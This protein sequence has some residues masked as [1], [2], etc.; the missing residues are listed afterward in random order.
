[1][2][3]NMKVHIFDVEHGS[4]NVIQTP[5]G[6]LIMIDCGHNTSTGWRPSNW[7]L[8]NGLSISNLAISNID[9]DHVSDLVNIDRCCMPDTI[10]TNWHLSADWIERK[11]KEIGGIG[12]G[13][14]KLL[15][16][17]QKIYTGDGIAV[18]YGLARK[19]FCL[20]TKDFTDFNNL[21]M[22]TFFQYAGFCIIFPGDLLKEGWKELL[23][24]S[25]FTNW[26]GKVNIFVASHHGRE[27]GYYEEVFHYCTPDIFIIS[28][29]PIKHDTQMHDKYSSQS[30]GILFGQK[31]RR[32]LTTRKDNKITIHVEPTG[33]YTIYTQS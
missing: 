3:D 10:K 22:V 26:L 31:R 5:N 4:C 1:M 21:S 13:V 11:K 7:I 8:S 2:A 30:T 32:V 12:P 6:K 16:Y 18:D 19:R 27:N 25:S 15:E 24:N 23:Q 14:N 20:S 29:K 28:D 9:E 17:K 33:I